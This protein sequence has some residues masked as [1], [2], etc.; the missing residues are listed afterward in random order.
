MWSPQDVIEIALTDVQE[1]KAAWTRS[2]LT[3]AINAALPDYLGIPDGVDIGRLLDQLTVEALRYAIPLDAARPGEDALPDALRRDD[4][5]SSYQAHGAQLY[6][7]PDHIRT[8]R[9]LSAATAPGG[10]AALRPEMARR[11]LEQLRHAG[12]ELGVDQAAAVRG[13]LTSGA[14]VESLVGPAGTGKSFVVGV[15]AHAWSDRTLYGGDL[16]RRVFG[17]ATSQIATDVLVG[18]GWPRATSP[19]GSPPRNGSPQ[20]PAAAERSPSRATEHGGDTPAIWWLSTSP[21]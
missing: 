11:Y 1:R 4:G 14:Q 13:V 7:T 20:A 17:L 6:C 3:R 9:I 18:K 12:I 16:P 15:I 5:E 8:E 10:A 21:P 2:D 19:G